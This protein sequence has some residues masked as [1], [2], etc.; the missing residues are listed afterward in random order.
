MN[1]SGTSTHEL[2]VAAEGAVVIANNSSSMR[3][4]LKVLYIS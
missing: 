3:Y 2:P 1:Y 4:V